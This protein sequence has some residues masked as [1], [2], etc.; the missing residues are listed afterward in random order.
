MAFEDHIRY[1]SPKGFSLTS[2]RPTDPLAKRNI[3]H[4]GFL[5]AMECVDDCG[6]IPMT[7][8]HFF[9]RIGE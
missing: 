3:R 4:G 7:V 5:R 9:V 1:Y 6:G 8:Y 2:E